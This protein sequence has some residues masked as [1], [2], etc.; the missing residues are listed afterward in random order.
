MTTSLYL[1]VILKKKDDTVNDTIL[2]PS[3]KESSHLPNYPWVSVVTRG[4]TRRN[5]PSPRRVAKVT[6]ESGVREMHLCRPRGSVCAR[7]PATLVPEAA[8]GV[9]NKTR[10]RVAASRSV[11]SLEDCGVRIVR[12]SSG[13]IG[14]RDGTKRNT[15]HRRRVCLSRKRVSAG[16]RERERKRRRE[17]GKRRQVACCRCASNSPTLSDFELPKVNFPRLMRLSHNR[18]FLPDTERWLCR[19]AL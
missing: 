13:T 11:N 14:T 9:G 17:E 8:H 16:E 15:H 7:N 19:R 1:T 3:N 6:N 2:H 5:S 10:Y 18:I 12:H 4:V